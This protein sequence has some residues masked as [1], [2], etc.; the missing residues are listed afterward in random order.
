MHIE[1]LTITDYKCFGELVLENLGSRVVLVGPNGCGKSAV[2]EAIAVLK[3]FVG[4][5]YS[6]VNHYARTLPTVG[7]GPSWPENVPIPVRAGQSKATITADVTFDA[8]EATIAKTEMATIGIE[9]DRGGRIRSTNVNNFVAEVFRLVNPTLQ[10][11]VIDYI[12]P[13]RTFPIQRVT[14]L[15]LESL[16]ALRLREELIELPR[17]DA[18]Y[19]KFTAIKQFII[20]KQLED[21]SH[22]Q[23][24]HEDRDSLFLLR[25]LFVDFFGPKR[26]VG[27][28]QFENEMQVAVETPSGTHD[29]DQL[30][31]GEKELFSIL[32]HL[33]RIRNLPSVILYD[34]PERHLNAA[35]ESRIIPALDKLKSCNQ[36]WIATHGLELIS[37]VPLADIISLK[38]ANGTVVAERYSDESK[39]ARVRIFE[40]LGARVGLQ[41]SAKR[42][43]F[44]E[45]KDSNSDKAILDSL[46][47][48]KLPG[49]L[50]V[51]SGTSTSVTGAGTRANLLLEE[52]S[53]DTAFSMI[54]DRD[55][56]DEAMV[57]EL[58]R[59]LNNRV[60]V[61]DCHEIENVL[62]IPKIIAKVLQ[63]NG[64]ADVDEGAVDAALKE[65]TEGL[66]GTFAAQW[67][68]HRLAQMERPESDKGSARPND[69]TGFRDMSV[70]RRQS[71]ETAYSDKNINNAFETAKKD[72]Q[73]CLANGTWKKLLPGKEILDAVRKRYLSSLPKELFINQLVARVVEDAVELP[74]IGSLVLFIADK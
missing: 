41:L 33:F 50:F 1:K 67:A 16:S 38:Q 20:S 55:Y 9:I 28:R 22:R 42:I 44:I 60:F 4:T 36:L 24:R 45:G 59:R 53:K 63:H 66:Q 71:V 15:A 49:T 25:E 32:V 73:K 13:Q 6:N 19:R 7:H 61:W 12:G 11:G 34:E 14:A 43:I 5:Y 69:E 29:I 47:A 18:N 64:I 17:E 51:A 31:S 40:N 37:S 3:K 39:V 10:V 2:L 48:P 56:R 23:N 74:E 54:L 8:Q 30:S 26:L 68:A 72:V 57:M 58:R 35:L 70:A 21:L 27:Y 65:A 46:A 62:M 52:A